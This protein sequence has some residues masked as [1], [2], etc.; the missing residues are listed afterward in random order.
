MKIKHWDTFAF[1]SIYHIAILAL[2]PF[3]FPA[4]SWV[5]LA[6][7][8]ITYIIGGMAITVGYHRLYAHKAYQANPFFEWCILIGS[9]FAFEMSALMWSHDHRNHHNHVDTE[10]DPYS[11]KKGF[12]YAHVLWLFDYD[13][14]YDKTL[15]TDLLKNKRVVFQDKYYLPIVLIVNFSVFFLGWAITGS[16]VASFFYGFL[17]RMALIHHCTWFIN[18]LC[19]TYGSKTYARELSAVDNAVLALLTFGEGY[20]NYHHAFAADYRNGIRWYHFD[21][22]KWTIWLASKLGMT[23]KLRTINTLTVQK[24]LVMKDKKMLVEHLS[25]EVDELAAEFKVKV[26][27]LAAVFEEKAAELTKKVRELKQASAD[28][29]E[30][31]ELEIKALK[32]SLKETWDEW[33]ALTRQATKQFE[34]SHAH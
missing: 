16:A 34:L 6:I 33:V 1:V 32:A 21:P 20:H 10:K 9:A 30:K 14:N 22:S 17:V 15:V 27:E 29:R 23:T 4:F 7:G 8:I 26:E 11:I 31:I 3:A 13:R 12:W 19:H 24:S 5:A 2:I 25:E 18:S 28:Q